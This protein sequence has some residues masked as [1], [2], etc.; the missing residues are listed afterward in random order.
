MYTKKLFLLLHCPSVSEVFCT[1]CKRV[2]RVPS[3]E[4]DAYFATECTFDMVPDFLIVVF[5]ELKIT[6]SVS[7]EGIE[8]KCNDDNIRL[9]QKSDCFGQNL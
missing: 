6:C 4:N 3:F 1:T 2:L 5:G 9:I 7:S 8:A